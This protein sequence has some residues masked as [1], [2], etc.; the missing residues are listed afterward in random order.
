MTY[1]GTVIEKKL[2][3]EEGMTFLFTEDTFLLDFFLI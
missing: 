1:N 2:V 3:F